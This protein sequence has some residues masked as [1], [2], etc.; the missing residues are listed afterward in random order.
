M[1][2][3]TILPFGIMLELWVYHSASDGVHRVPARRCV[4]VVLFLCACA[5]ILATLGLPGIQDIHPE[6][7]K[8]ELVLIPLLP[9]LD[10]PLGSLKNLLL[11]VPIGFLWPLIWK[12]STKQTIAAGALYS[13]AVELLQLLNWRT[14]N[15]NDWLLNLAGAALGCAFFRL[16]QQRMP[17]AELW[18]P[19]ATAAQASPDG[20]LRYEKRIC[21]LL[22]WV[23]QFFFYPCVTGGITVF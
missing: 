23:S 14:T 2:M 18:C 22:P 21:I 17:G 11:F 9:M 19:P 4:F 5:G 3:A 15:L 7:W 6:N 10:N 12:S 8:E 16:L 13:L 1:G 20:P